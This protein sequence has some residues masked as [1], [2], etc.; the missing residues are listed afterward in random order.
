MCQSDCNRV[1]L[2]NG[3]GTILNHTLKI[4]TDKVALLDNDGMTTDKVIKD[5]IKK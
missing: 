3:E 4:N 2:S 1:V 5:A